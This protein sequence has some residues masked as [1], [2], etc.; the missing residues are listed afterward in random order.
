MENAYASAQA[1]FSVPFGL[2][3][4]IEAS[5]RQHEFACR[6]LDEFKQAGEEAWGAL[7]AGVETVWKDINASAKGDAN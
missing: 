7:K 1:K 5:Q 6:N 4:Q 2:Q 3:K